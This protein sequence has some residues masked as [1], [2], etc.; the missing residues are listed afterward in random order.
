MTSP[1]ATPSGS[2]GPGHVFHGPAPFQSGTGNVQY[3]RFVYQWQPAYRI[4]DFPAAPRRIRHRDLAEQPSRLLRAGHQVVSFTGRSPELNELA[5]WRD[6]PAERL[7]V[8]LTHG[9]G[10]QG[11]TRLAAHFA[12]LS[13]RAQWSVWQASVNEAGADPLDTTA[14][15]PTA[16]GV[17]LVV[18]YAERWPVPD[19][20]RLLREPL[21]YRGGFPVRVLLLARP[22]GT[23]WDS[24]A[25]W[26]DDELDARADARPLLPLAA[27]VRGAGQLFEQARDRFAEHL[28]LPRD[29]AVSIS[30]P[31][32]LDI[33][34]DYAQVLTIHMAALAAVDARIHGDQAPRDPARA[35]L[36]LLKRERA[37]WS[38]LHE[39]E[40]HPLG[41][42]PIA[43]GRTVLTATLTRPLARQHGWTALR[44]VGL[45][46]STE[47]A[48]TLLDD[49]QYCYPS[50][51]RDSVL[52]PLYPDR[53]GED[54]LGLTIPAEDH[55][56]P[57][58]VTDDWAQHAAERLLA[59]PAQ[60]VPWTREALIVLIETARRWPHI[61]TGQ[62]YPLLTSHPE[63]ALRAGGAALA[64]L[65][66]LDGIDPAVLEAIEPCL[67]AER[68]TDLDIGIATVVYRLAH[69]RLGA[70]RDPAEHG[71]VRDHLARRLHYAGLR[72]EALVAAVDAL[73]AWRHVVRIDPGYRPG[74]A[75]SL[76]GLALHLSAVGRFQE[77]LAA[78]EE[79]V[80]LFRVVADV[81]PDAY[82]EN[83]A[84]ALVECGGH[85]STLGR[86]REALP[87][88]EEG[89][90][91]FRALAETYPSL[92]LSLARALINLGKDLSELGRHEEALAATEEALALYRRSGTN[93]AAHEPDLALLLTNLG[94]Q[95][96]ELGRHA[97]ALAA[98]EEAVAVYRRQAAT[99]FAAHAP[100]LARA[101]SNLSS[102]LSMAGRREDALVAVEEAL[103]VYR[104]LVDADPT[105]FTPLLAVSLFNLSKCQSDLGRAAEAVAAAE[106][107]LA[108]H[109]ELAELIP[110]VHRYYVA[111]SLSNLSKFLSDLGRDEAA[112]SAAEESVALFRDLREA[113]PT[114]Y[115]ADLARALINLS[116]DLSDFGRHE[117]ALAAVE[118]ALSLYRPLAEANPGAQ[119]PALAVAHSHLSRVLSA[120]GRAEEALA[121]AAEAVE[122]QRTLAGV[123]PAEPASG[124]ADSLVTFSYLLSQQGRDEEA[125][126]ATEEALSHY[127]RLATA[128]P[129]AYEPDMAEVLSNLAIDLSTVDRPRDA[130]AASQEALLIH[131]R[132][133][134]AGPGDFPVP[135]DGLAEALAN[136]AHYLSA[137]GRWEE[138][139]ALAEEAVS[140]QRTLT[141]PAHASDLARSLTNL[142]Y[143]CTKAERYHEALAA[144]VEVVSLRRQLV[145][146][147]GTDHEFDLA[148]CLVNLGYDLSAVGRHEDALAATDDA[149]T[150]YRRLPDCEPELREAGQQRAEIR[151][152]MEPDEP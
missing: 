31:A 48:N 41:T 126:L 58:A 140:A 94:K 149:L 80:S 152:R 132:L 141:G 62:L 89:V 87:L 119:R 111:F 84:A 26:L 90:G 121:A 5:Q 91:C 9:P 105:A 51:R 59:A 40:S 28:G 7:A 67:P 39:R 55:P 97:E 70:T 57:D 77:A 38:A 100:D 130:L 17:L 108:L 4:E 64:A 43:M 138:A 106:E 50:A 75:N 116:R 68:H 53:L 52:E 47:A 20:R 73:R 148:E 133:A 93:P 74:L 14:P 65:A 86:Y 32:E 42:T 22:A 19:L 11:K 10:G 54:F 49:H 112:L 3:N 45:A 109:R 56:V 142:S 118:E 33:D 150:L 102:Y 99:N 21:L 2:G 85:M 128:D 101:L 66:N 18:D 127:R 44:H 82:Q 137:V 144:T 71:R 35:S 136:V 12:E 83:L 72:A 129:A 27:T 131:R 122:I 143:L 104:P 81:D 113:T 61:A 114:L 25:T 110:A 117:E 124:L 103:A 145:A 95:L 79:A 135:D 107:A 76:Y 123:T 46:D 69:H 78:C 115:A 29:Q 15:G 6:D 147:E 96:S 98:T 151:R 63:L 125:L 139:V 134:E 92:Q 36:Y 24:L 34:D 30:P 13:R 23:W 146:A 1:A 60:P 8:R 16:R 120:A 88:I 37:H